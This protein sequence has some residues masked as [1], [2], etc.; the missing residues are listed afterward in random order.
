MRRALAG[1][2]MLLAAGAA[3]AAACNA[4]EI[5][6][7]ARVGQ[8]ANPAPWVIG[9]STA[10]LA[11]PTLGRMGVETD[12]HGCRWFDQ[13]VAMV[14]RRPLRRLGDAVVLALGANGSVTRA[15]IARARRVVGPRR[16]LLLVTPRNYAAA[17]GAMLAA[18]RAHPDQVR[19]LDW[20]VR[21][22]GHGEW[23]AGDGLHVSYA[24]ARV[25]ARMIREGLQ[26][27]FAPR[28]PLTLP[29]GRSGARPCGTVRA[30]GRRTAVYLV[31][32]AVGCAI[33]RAMLGR[34]RL[35]LPPT[36]RFYDWRTVGRG[37]WTDVVARRDRSIVL[38]G[39]TR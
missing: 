28:H 5:A 23:F 19:T 20:T 6:T 22:A 31:R 10:I 33:A 38:A 14:A 11:A 17:R 4:G 2:L 27:F 16:F 24:G 3:P 26:P 13:G 30:Y 34:P 25:W 1:A 9:D 32:G 39:I 21:S 15:Q 7:P 18:A 12:A 36:W 29:Q 35:A 8:R 37:P